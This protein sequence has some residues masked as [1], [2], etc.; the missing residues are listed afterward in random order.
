MR[1]L[2]LSTLGHGF[3]WL[4]QSTK[5]LLYFTFKNWPFYRLVFV[6]NSFP[7][8]RCW[9]YSSCDMHYALLYAIKCSISFFSVNLRGFADV[10]KP[11]VSYCYKLVCNI[12]FLSFSKHHSVGLQVMPR[13][14]L[15]LPDVSKEPKYLQHPVWL[16]LHHQG[17]FQLFEIFLYWIV[18]RICKTVWRSS[19]LESSNN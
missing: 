17:V 14:R 15:S 7:E 18:T 6:P 5:D 11:V 19:S 12:F 3:P 16:Q 1:L 9:N 2:Q 13:L 8:K 4:F 10:R